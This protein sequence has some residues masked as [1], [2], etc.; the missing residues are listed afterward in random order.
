MSAVIDHG[1]RVGMAYDSLRHDFIEAVYRNPATVIR[2]PAYG[3]QRHM[4]A[5][6][7]VDDRFAEVDGGD[8]LHEA[9]AILVA[10]SLGK[11]CQLRASAL[12][13]RIA[14]EHASKHCE[15]AAEG[16]E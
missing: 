15:A 13:A 7:V 1:I 4:T 16:D 14:K 5:A 11:E 2:T 10:A 3:T 9:V 6:E 8:D 12:L